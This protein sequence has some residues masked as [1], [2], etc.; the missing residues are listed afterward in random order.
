M[1]SRISILILLAVTLA[2]IRV[3]RAASTEE[4]EFQNGRRI[5]ATSVK[6]SGPG[7]SA[8]VT[9]GASSQTVNFLAKDV[10]RATFWEPL[11]LAEARTFI[12]SDKPQEALAL[13][14]KLTAK[15]A[16]FQT[17]RGS[18]W[19]RAAILHMDALASQGK[20]D[21]AVALVPPDLL[22]KLPVDAAALITD[23]QLI[24]AKPAASP[25]AKIP[26]MQALAKRSSDPWM[27]ARA[28][29]EIGSLFSV[30]GKIEEA[31][32][33][34]LRVPV[35]HA[36][37]NDLAVRGLV[38][39]ARGLHQLKLAEDGVKLLNDYLN[40]HIGSPFQSVIKAEIVKLD[41]KQT[42]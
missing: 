41:P 30:Q 25:D 6:A 20:I 14:G 39:A 15:L 5:P 13:M 12:A 36:A 10:V 3:S 8:T 4:F 2:S 33:A 40:A 27:S 19:H 42:P 24:I 37:E 35:F 28:W 38:S 26:E 32:K 22:T 29:L 18:W 17:I 1:S 34:W 31:F 7:F 11:E 9:V 23:F 16:P 21:E